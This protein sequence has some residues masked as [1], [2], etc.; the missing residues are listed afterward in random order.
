MGLTSVLLLFSLAALASGYDNDGRVVYE[1]ESHLRNIRQLTFGGSNAEAYFSYDNKQLTYQATLTGSTNCDQ[2]YRHDLTQDP[3]SQVPKRMSTGLGATTCSFFMN[4]N[5]H[6]L[7]AGTFHH[8]KYPD[9]QKPNEGFDTCNP[10]KCLHIETIVDPKLRDLCNTSYT[11]DI[12]N[13]YDIFLA[14]K[15][16][17]IVSRL[18]DA[19]GYDAEGVV[20]PDGTKIAYTSM[21]SGDLELWIMNIDGSNKTMLTNTLG[22]DGGS[23]F[24]PDGT[25]LI[26]RASRPKTDAEKQKYIDLRSYDLVAPTDMELFWVPVDG[27]HKEVQITWLGGANWAPYYHHDGKRIIFAT[28]HNNTAGFG[29]FDLWMIE[30]SGNLDTLERITWD[31]N[32]FDSFPMFSWD[33]KQLVWGSSRNASNE[34]D[35]NLFIADWVDPPYDDDSVSSLSIFTAL[36]VLCLRFFQ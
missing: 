5:E 12:Y 33:G 9:A 14:D 36:A 30:E 22:Y 4:D 35:L 25:K 16:G 31:N 15:Y 26:F 20:S 6:F 13:E 18:T 34:Y 7:Y 10:K 11:W 28:D 23:F 1:G 29:A 21:S 8:V 24:S 17:N 32:Q 19:P 3:R 2:I 27:S